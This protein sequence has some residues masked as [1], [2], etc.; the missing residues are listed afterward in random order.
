MTYPNN[1]GLYDIHDWPRPDKFA[2]SISRRLIDLIAAEINRNDGY[3]SFA[4]FM[5]MA[6]YH[7]GLGYYSAGARK[8][9]EDGDFITAPELSPL[10]SYCLARQCEELIREFKATI[11]LELGAGSGIMA[12]DILKELQRRDSLPDAYYILEPSADLRDRQRRLLLDTLPDLAALVTW[13]DKLPDQSFR[14]IILANE[15]FDA[16]PIHRI[17][18]INGVFHELQVSVD[19]KLFNSMI[20]PPEGDLTE[21]IINIFSAQP[22]DLPEG[23]VTE[24]NMSLTPMMTSLSSILDEGLIILIDYG[25]P[26]REY[27][28]PQRIDGT[29]QCYYRH[30]VHTDPFIFVGLQDIT[31]SVDFTAIAESATFIELQLSG[32]TTQ[33][34]FLIGN[35]LHT[36]IEEY[37]SSDDKL[38]TQYSHQAKQLLLPGK[39]GEQI[40]VMALSKKVD[41]PLSGFR[42][43]D[44]QYRL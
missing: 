36:I 16:M 40:K 2:E 24:I 9:G 23:Y 42:F 10:F 21:K 38:R 32:F 6:L 19:K 29:L 34:N 5:K 30:R 39:M 17:K 28:H 8:F 18:N 33:A 4:E 25:Y 15:V 43:A 35:G 37:G 26:R 22:N 14:G 13:L 31:S 41:K 1:T 3:I 27:Y 12:R 7:P 20:R 11:I 44:H